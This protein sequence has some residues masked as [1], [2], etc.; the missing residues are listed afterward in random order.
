MAALANF[1]LGWGRSLVTWL[2]NSAI[3]LL[4]GALDGFCAFVLTLVSLFPSGP[5][6]P[7]LGAS[8]SGAVWVSFLQALNWF[9][10]VGFFVS[11]VTFVSAGMLAYV[12]IM[13]LAR[14]VKALS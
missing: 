1:L 2:Y 7:V 8:P 13:V 6:L 9:F 11:I 4:Q 12:A 14:W 5:T 10:P 3:D